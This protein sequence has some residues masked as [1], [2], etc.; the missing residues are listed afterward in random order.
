MVERLTEAPGAPGTAALPVPQA[1]GRQLDPMMRESLEE[2]CE[3]IP[4]D[5]GGGASLL[6]VLVLADLIVAN[7]LSRIVEIG[8]Y[9]GRVLLSLGRLM[10]LLERGEV[11][12]ID[13]YCEAAAV[14]RQ[15]KTQGLDLREWPKSVD[16]DGLHRS[17]LDGFDQWGLQGHAR[18]IRKRSRHA[19]ASFA[20]EAIDLLHIDGNHDHDAVVADVELFLPHMSERGILVLDDVSWPTIRPVF[21]TLLREHELL[22]SIIE[23]GV[24]LWPSDVPNDFAVLRL[25]NS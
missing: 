22:L 13:P 14:Q 2:V 17:L 7:D 5:E 3:S 12:G 11:M 25:R 9:R 16:W 20:G 8:V 24:N 6:K 15:A 21:E 10:S 18:L 19:A 4:V 1:F 23:K